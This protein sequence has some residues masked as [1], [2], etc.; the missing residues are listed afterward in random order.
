MADKIK[1]HTNDLSLDGQTLRK[2]LIEN[3]KIIENVINGM[4]DEQSSLQGSLGL[5]SKEMN[6]IKGGE[7]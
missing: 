2:Q 5:S 6:L 4:Q 3:F 7:S 1:L